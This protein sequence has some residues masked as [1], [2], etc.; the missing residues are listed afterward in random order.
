[1]LKRA[2][3]HYSEIEKGE[4]EMIDSGR[5]FWFQMSSSCKSVLRF[6]VMD[7]WESIARVS[8]NP[9]TGE[10]LGFL[11]AFTDRDPNIIH[12][13]GILAFKQNSK[14]FYKDSIQF[15][16]E[17]LVRFNRVG[18]EVVVGNPAEKIYDKMIRRWGGRIVG[19]R[20]AWARLTDGRLYDSKVYEIL[21]VKETTYR[22]SLV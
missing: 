22:S 20:C 14:T 3:H 4:K 6:A 9:K 1:M 15:V 11:V 10:V 7:E 12:G 2:Q 21:S 17:L 5:M 16:D 18:W 8:V 19:T 13:M